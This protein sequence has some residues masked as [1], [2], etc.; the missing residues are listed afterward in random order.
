MIYSYADY[1]KI[2]KVGDVVRAV[3]GKENACANLSDDGSNTGKITKVMGEYF[4]NY[5]QSYPK[6]L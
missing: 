1:L 3:K 6:T 4:G 5:I 2:A